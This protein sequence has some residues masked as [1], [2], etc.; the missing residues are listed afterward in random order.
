ME[1][2]PS[3]VSAAADRCAAYLLWFADA[4]GSELNFAVD[5]AKQVE[6]D[7]KKVRSTASLRHASCLSASYVVAVTRTA[8]GVLAFAFAEVNNRHTLPTRHTHWF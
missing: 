6:A 3:R 8:A 1:C 4:A 7:G 5:A 2:P